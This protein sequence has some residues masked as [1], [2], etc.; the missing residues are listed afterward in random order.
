MFKKKILNLVNNCK[1]NLNESIFSSKINDIIKVVYSISKI[2]DVNLTNN[3]NL[4]INK[5]INIIE[6]YVISFMNNNCEKLAYSLLNIQQNINIE[7]NGILRNLKDKEQWK[8]QIILKFKKEFILSCYNNTID[9]IYYKISQIYCDYLEKEYKN[10][11]EEKYLINGIHQI[12]KF[13]KI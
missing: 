8:E 7:F 11:L 10:Y 2:E 12:G 1:N 3:I 5:I 9:Q 4:L 13:I 6:N